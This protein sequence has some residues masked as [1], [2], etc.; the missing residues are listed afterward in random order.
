[1]DNNVIII[2]NFYDTHYFIFRSLPILKSHLYIQEALSMKVDY[3]SEIRNY[4]T[5]H[6]YQSELK[7]RPTESL[8]LWTISE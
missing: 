3:C 2:I 4:G 6:S 5:N 1:M 8:I 7:R